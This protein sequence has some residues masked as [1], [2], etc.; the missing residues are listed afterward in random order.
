MR[1]WMKSLMGVTAMLSL[2]LTGRSTAVL[3]LDGAG[4]ATRTLEVPAGER[5]RLTLPEGFAA[6]SCNRLLVRMSVTFAKPVHPELPKA[7]LRWGEPADDRC[8]VRLPVRA[9]GQP[10]DYPFI[11]DD[12]PFW[13][14]SAQTLELEPVC[15]VAE[16]RVRIEA[17]ELSRVTKPT[18]DQLWD[19][20]A[21]LRTPKA[22]WGPERHRVVRDDQYREHRV[23]TRKVWYENEPLKGRP[24]RV[25]AF[26]S[27]PEGQG[28]FPGMVLI[29]GGGGTAFSDW[30]ELW[31]ARGYAAISMDHYGSEPDGE[32]ATSDRRQR[33]RLPDGGPNGSIENPQHLRR[34]DC[35]AYHAAAAV[36]RA[37]SLLR[38]L[39]QVDAERTGV[40]G[41]SWGGYLTSLVIGID[42]RFKVA[43]PF[44]GCGDLINSFMDTSLI[45]MGAANAAEWRLTLDPISFIHHFRG[46]LLLANN[47]DDF[48]FQLEAHRAT[49]QQAR[50]TRDGADVWLEVGMPHSMPNARRPQIL[51]YV[52]FAL[53]GGQPLP[54]LTPLT[55]SGLTFHTSL[56]YGAQAVR[57]RLWLTTDPGGFDLTKSGVSKWTKRRWRHIP[58][59]LNGSSITATLPA[60][61]TE[62]PVRVFIDATDAAGYTCST[63][64]LLVP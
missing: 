52:D 62:R 44:Y 63:H 31:A 49:W 25:M 30:T 46:H 16:G 4:R 54:C 28:P 20:P 6:T 1:C 36:V 17:V 33:H 18:P 39:P 21:L 19:V 11:L 32:E 40:T 60:D 9:D 64:F 55:R 59:S 48:A 58:A 3:E 15:R 27:L 43:I 41:M 34:Q 61:V 45:A 14:G 8:A 37:H 56:K 50:Q 5:V 53:N 35:W 51:R 2:S 57:A 10:H 23:V 26:V 29:H 47:T 7:F 24:T 12:T 42:P 38:S 13:Q 22:E